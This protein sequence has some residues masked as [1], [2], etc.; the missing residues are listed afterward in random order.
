[1]LYIQEDIRDV[2]MQIHAF[3]ALLAA[4][5]TFAADPTVKISSGTYV[6]RYLAEFGQDV[7]LGIP[8]AAKPER[9]TPATL[10]VEGGGV[11]DAKQ[12]GYSC[13]GYG[14]D[15][16]KMVA[17]GDIVLNE[18]CLNLNVIRPKTGKDGLPVLVWIYG[19]GWQQVVFQ[20]LF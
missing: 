14:S 9:F 15:T 17:S 13:P 11:K 20:L 6:G 5:F 4:A 19:G 7:F 16:R 3:A 2:M 8:Y 12:Y 10:L 18:D 1:M